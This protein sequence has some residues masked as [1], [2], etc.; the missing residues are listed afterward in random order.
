ML[1]LWSGRGSHTRAAFD[2]TVHASAVLPEGLGD[3]VACPV[4]S[5]DDGVC[6]HHA[7]QR[8][9]WFHLFDPQYPLH[10]MHQV[11]SLSSGVPGLGAP[12]LPGVP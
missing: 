10:L 8:T 9:S 2:G 5:S 12:S 3:A 11:A 6:T 7:L 1:R 4:L